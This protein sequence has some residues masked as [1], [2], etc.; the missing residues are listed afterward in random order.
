MRSNRLSVGMTVAAVHVFVMSIRAAAPQE[1]VLHNFNSNGKDGI[2]P[3]SGLIFDQAGNLRGTTQ[4]GGTGSCTGRSF[5]GCST[6]F[7]LSPKKGGGW[8]EKILHNFVNDGVDGTGPQAGLV[9]DA[10]GN[11]Y[12]TVFRAERCTYKGN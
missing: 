10:A 8:G 11:L 9:F 4:Y 3:V 2:G 6:V 1:K 12:G 5:P 7:A